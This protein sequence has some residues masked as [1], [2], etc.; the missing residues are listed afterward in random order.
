[1]TARELESAVR[2]LERKQVRAREAA[3][4]AAACAVL[5]AAAAA[6]SITASVACLVGAAAATVIALENVA[7]RRNLIAG[8]ALEPRAHA[9]A[10][11]RDYGR[12]LVLPA[13][14]EKLAAWLYEVVREAAV[15]GSW[16]LA[17]RV[18]RYATQLELLASEFAASWL[19]V[20]PASAA[21]CRHLLTH[22]AESPLY[23]PDIPAEELSATIQ[24]IRRGITS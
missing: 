24:R 23:N 16:Y 20:R 11:V 10:P 12:Q 22:A 19:R 17:D 7:S 2:T 1:M 3:V 4:A 6:L 9:I 5:A 13:E 15:P 18:S 21:A 8:L 14:R